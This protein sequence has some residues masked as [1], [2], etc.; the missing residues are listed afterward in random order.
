M[1]RLVAPAAALAALAAA[2]PVGAAGTTTTG[3]VGFDPIP[4]SAYG[5]DWDPAAPWIIPAGFTQE[6]VSDEGDLDIYSAPGDDW[7]DM[8]TVNET[9][10]HA[11]RYL[12]R[13]HEV[14][15]GAD[16]ASY[17]GGSLSVVDLRTGATKLLVQRHDW[18]ALDGLVWTPWGTLLFAEETIDAAIPDPDV[19]EAESGLLYELFLDPSDPTTAARVVARP[20]VGSV[21][22]EGIEVGPDGSVFVIDE[23]SAGAIYRFVPDRR[24]DLSSGRLFALAVDGPDGTGQGKWVPLDRAAVQVNAREHVAELNADGAGIAT[25]GRPEDLELIGGVLYVAITSEDRVLAV[26]L[27]S[28]RVST[29]VAA[30]RNVAVESKGA[31][32][33]GFDSPDN[34]ADGPDG[35]LWIVED[36]VP[37][38]IWV[39]EKDNDGDGLADG[40]HLFASLTDS[41]AEG[42][43]IYFGSDPRTLFV[44]V[45]H[46]LAPSGDATWRIT[47]R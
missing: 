1:R 15:P 31:G 23:Y 22:H 32:V 10:R 4:G 12:Y 40:V 44:N 33:T 36:N 2:L 29:F 16:L 18:E 30:G 20:A 41:G 43:G 35:R 14:R 11:G 27:S 9:G 25:Y 28:L 7:P 8:N 34:L 46:S 24:G 47:R 5:A 38:D 42:T 37:S 26:D 6:V 45:Q 13:T 39:A 19:P 21:S 3:P 17:A